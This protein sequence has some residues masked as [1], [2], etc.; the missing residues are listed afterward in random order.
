MSAWIRRV[1]PAVVSV[2]A[3][4]AGPARAQ[5]APAPAQPDNK[6]AAKEHYL[7]GTSYYDLGRYDEA[8]REFEAAY[9]FK[10]DPAFLYNLAQSYRQAGRPEQALHF[11]RTYLRYVPKP[12]NK[13]DIEE[14]IEALEKQIA[15]KGPGTTPPPVG[16]TPPPVGTPPPPGHT[17]P[18]QGTSPPPPAGD[19]GTVPLP[20]GTPPPGYSPPP[21]YTPPGD[22]PPPPET[23]PDPGKKFRIAGLAAG[24]TAAIFYLVGIVQ[25]RRAASASEE[26]ESAARLGLPFDPA[27]EERGK[28]AETAQWWLFGLGTLIAASGAGLWYYGNRM[29][30]GADTTTWRIAVAPIIAP[31]NTGAT[32]RIS[33]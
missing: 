1:L 18:P 27:D 30:A 11:Y 33:F 9:H 31:Q 13:A 20:P 8:I 7:R 17:A 23:S 2:I 19:L 21:G 22:M 16:T 28:S 25:W 10:N 32:L 24:G 5:Q 15:Q 12:P 4:C 3:L 29:V 26:V 6:A 14:K